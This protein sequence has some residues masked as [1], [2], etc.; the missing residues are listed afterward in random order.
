MFQK[1]S[2]DTSENFLNESVMSFSEIPKSKNFNFISE[3]HA[4][5]SSDHGGGQ[6]HVGPVGDIRLSALRLLRDEF[7]KGARG[8]SPASAKRQRKHQGQFQV[9]ARWD[10]DHQNRARGLQHPGHRIRRQL[11]DRHRILAEGRQAEVEQLVFGVARPRRQ[12]LE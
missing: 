12:V 2:S 5:L 8:K 3:L 9:P 4:S 1:R 10:R 6:R 7:G 11:Q